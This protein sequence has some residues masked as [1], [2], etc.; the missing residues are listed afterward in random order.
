MRPPRPTAECPT[1]YGRVETHE[2]D[3]VI[4]LSSAILARC[5]FEQ[6]SALVVT[7]SADA[8]AAA[9]ILWGLR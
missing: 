2:H 1:A 6:S 3:V 5:D 4:G 7:F 8:G 9:L